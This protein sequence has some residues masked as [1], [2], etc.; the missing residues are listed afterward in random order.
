MSATLDLMTPHS[1]VIGLPIA[2][3]PRSRDFY[4]D[5]LGF[6]AP[7]ELADD[8]VPEPLQLALSETVSVMLVPAG[9]FGWAIGGRPVAP[10]DQHECVFTLSV[11]SESDVDA[12]LERARSAGAE[13]V[14]G[15]TRQPWGYTG[16]FADPDGHLWS[17]LVDQG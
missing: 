2:D 6:E 13:I 11:R 12:L 4:R 16:T 8:G 14:T 9:G 10:A 5:V 7:G 15:A 3:R 17:A 1:I